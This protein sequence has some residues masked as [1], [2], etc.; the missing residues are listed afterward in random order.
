M[1]QAAYEK[2]AEHD[3]ETFLQDWQRVLEAVVRL[4]PLRVR[5]PAIELIVRK[6]GYHRPPALVSRATR[7]VRSASA[8]WRRPRAIAFA[9][10]LT[11]RGRSQ[12]SSLDDAE[13]VLEA[14]CEQTS[15]ILPIP[16]VTRRRGDGFALTAD[17]DAE[18]LLASL[19]PGG[20]EIWFRLTFVWRNVS[21]QFRLSRPEGREP[22]AEIAFDS[23]GGL[24]LRRRA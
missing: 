9:G 20:R 16:L 11:V 21:R 14:V 18:G 12:V 19:A 8:G 17:I 6:L 2:A 15:Q 10:E 24:T 3:A 7:R 1:S 5:E 4:K 22:A 23:A 13:V